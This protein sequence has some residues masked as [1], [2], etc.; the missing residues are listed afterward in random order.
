MVA[1]MTEIKTYEMLEVMPVYWTDGVTSILLNAVDQ[2]VSVNQG[3]QSGQ[4]T[5]DMV[6]PKRVLTE[7]I[8][9]IRDTAES[10]DLKNLYEHRCQICGMV[11]SLTNRLYSE[12]H[13]LQPLGANHKGPDVRANMIVVC[14]NHH[15]LLDAGAIAI[16]P[17]THK[18]INY[19]GDE[20]GRLVEAAD[21]QL[22]SKYLTYHFEKRFK[23]RV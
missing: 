23:T 7:V 13:H 12:T 18:V 8:R 22:D 19:Q 5:N 3:E 10:R 11:L 14:P 4:Q 21:H 2:S 1:L 17:E 6:L 20:I 9:V 15:A 16:D